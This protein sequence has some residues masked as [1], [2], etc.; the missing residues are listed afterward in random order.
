MSTYTK[1]MLVVG[2]SILA[3]S[4]WTLYAPLGDFKKEC[5]QTCGAEGMDYEV[6]SLG[7]NAPPGGYPARCDCVPPAPRAWWEFWKNDP[8]P[9]SGRE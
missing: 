3:L 1:F 2:G 7:R 5:A 4:F 9:V 6:V 8:P